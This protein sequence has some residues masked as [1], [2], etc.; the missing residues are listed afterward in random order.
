MAARSHHVGGAQFLLGDGGVRFASDNI[1][2]KVW[3]GVG[4]RAGGEV[5]G[6]F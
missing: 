1:D 5:L 3:E 6:E 4:T 2:G